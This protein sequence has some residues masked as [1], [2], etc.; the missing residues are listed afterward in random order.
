MHPTTDHCAPPGD[1]RRY[2]LLGYTAIAIVAGG[3]GIWAGTAPLDS[4]AIA[5]ARVAVESDRKP[6]QH[7]EGG[8][9]REI[10]VKENQRV[11][12]GQSLCYSAS[13][14]DGGVRF[15]R[16]DLDETPGK[17]VRAPVII[18]P[19][20]ARAMRSWCEKHVG[21]R[22][23]IPGVLAFKLPFVR[24]RLNWWFCSEICT[25]ALQQVG[26]LRGVKA[27]KTSPNSLFRMA[28]GLL[29]REHRA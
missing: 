24:H 27:H 16:I 18:E 26:L 25:A 19:E 6:I 14:R 3:F 10:L 23:D 29:P 2:A 5:P 22:Y 9:V 8:I 11:E 12:E 21:G 15:K 4:A 17:W 20:E 28:T 7:L 13:Y 1:Y